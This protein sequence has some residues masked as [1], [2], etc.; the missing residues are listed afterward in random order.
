MPRFNVA[1]IIIIPNKGLVV[2]CVGCGGMAFTLHV[3]P[4]DGHA[5]LYEVVCRTCGK[6]HSIGDNAEI[7]GKEQV[8]DPANRARTVAGRTYR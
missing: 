5:K 8:H 1:P 2:D 4:Q 7:A 6:K 3:M